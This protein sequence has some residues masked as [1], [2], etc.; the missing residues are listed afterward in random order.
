MEAALQLNSLQLLSFTL[1]DEVF[2]IEISRVRE[3]LEIL[4]EPV[5]HD[6]S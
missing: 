2:A 6:V 5:F 3:V 1:D 4:Y